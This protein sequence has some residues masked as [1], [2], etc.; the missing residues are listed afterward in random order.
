M[1]APIHAK[2]FKSGNS[3]AI[4]LPKGVGFGIG[5]EMR[6]ERD[7]HRIVL[8]PVTDPAE[9]KRKLLRMLAELD[10]LPKPSYT[11]TH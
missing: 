6:V 8:T 7:A 1:N 2:T 10:A 9:E 11:P 3:E 5:T 4:R